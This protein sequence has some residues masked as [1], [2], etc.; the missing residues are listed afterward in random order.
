MDEAW[1]PISDPRHRS[2]VDSCLQLGA[3]WL[4]L[5]GEWGDRCTVLD[6]HGEALNWPVIMM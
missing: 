6:E 3:F 1:L 2:V 5:L 4:A